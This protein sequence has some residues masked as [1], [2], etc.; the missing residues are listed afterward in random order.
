MSSGFVLEKA[1][2][3]FWMMFMPVFVIAITKIMTFFSAM[4]FAL[5]VSSLVTLAYTVNLGKH[6]LNLFPKI[7]FYSLRNQLL[8]IF[9]T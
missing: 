7:Q 4:L 5:P 3:V 1:Y 8:L 9:G 6:F 2:A